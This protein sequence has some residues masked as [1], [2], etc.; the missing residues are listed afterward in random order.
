MHVMTCAM[1]AAGIC[2]HDVLKH[3]YS[4]DSAYQQVN[5]Q[6]YLK[7]QQQQHQQIFTLCVSLLYGHDCVNK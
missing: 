3:M 7:Q 4:I 2:R 6:F 1:Y 5:S